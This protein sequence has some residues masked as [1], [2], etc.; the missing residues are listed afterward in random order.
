MKN[1]MIAAALVVALGAGSLLAEGVPSQSKLNNLGLSSM[2]VATDHDGMQVR[3]KGFVKVLF[4]FKTEAGEK[5]IFNNG[6]FE[7]ADPANFVAN[8]SDSGAGIA[9]D[10]QPLS[11]LLAFPQVASIQSQSLHQQDFLDAQGNVASEVSA[12]TT[13]AL[14]FAGDAILLGFFP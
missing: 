1:G 2:Q 13:S 14:V 4:N 12:S 3:G 7:S 9:S 8:A 5:A 10:G 6:Q 11:Y